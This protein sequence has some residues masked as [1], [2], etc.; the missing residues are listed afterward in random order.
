M[1][2]DLP[3]DTVELLEN[4]N[5]RIMSFSRNYQYLIAF[6]GRSRK[7]ADPRVRRALNMAI[8]RDAI[9][10]KV[11]KGAALPATGPIWPKHWAYDPSAG[12]YAY[13]PEGAA[14][15]LE[16][17]G[18]PMRSSQDEALPPARLRLTCLVPSQFS[19]LE[20]VA[21]EVQRQLSAIGVDMH[22]DVQPFRA[23]DERAKSGDFE[24]VMV[25]LI[26]GPSLSRASIMW[27]SPT[28]PD[29]LKYFGYHNPLTEKLFE[30]LRVTSDAAA[31]RIGVRKLQQAFLDNPPAV[32]LAWNERTRAVRAGFQVTVEP[33]T[34][35][36]T[37][38]WRWGTDKQ[39]GPDD[40]LTRR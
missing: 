7:F 19:V 1:V 9:I 36:L 35:P 17:A 26:A 13:D 12:S 25:D 14:A 18:L 38:L 4:D 24:T 16:A 2:T 20:H 5:V 23:Y 37:S 31:T 32:F 33:G 28:R 8:D 3:P 10:Q 6:N 30:E 11:L 39:D 40:R 29:V 34:D 15:L 27:R 22:F 21:L